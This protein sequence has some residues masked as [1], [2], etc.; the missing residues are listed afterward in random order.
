MGD[1]VQVMKELNERKLLIK[2]TCISLLEILED[3][4]GKGYTNDDLIDIGNLIASVGNQFKAVGE[5]RKRKE[6]LNDFLDHV[7]SE[8]RFNVD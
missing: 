5:D 7:G 6:D 8:H 3:P 2:N 1:I 4:S